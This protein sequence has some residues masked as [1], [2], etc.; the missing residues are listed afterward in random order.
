MPVFRTAAQVRQDF[1]DFFRERQHTVVPSASLVPPPGDATLLFINSGMAPFKDVFLEKMTPPAPRVADTQKCLRVS[2]KHNDLEEVGVDTY[3][4]TFFEMLGNWSFGDYFKT[5]A[6][7]WAW[8]LLTERWDLDPK[9]LYVTVHG[10]DERLGLG[11]DDEAAEIWAR[12][13]GL[14][15]SHILNGSTKDNFWMMGDTGPC[16][17]CTEIHIDLRP[18]DERAAVDGASLVNT[19]DPRVMEIWNNVFIQYNALSD[20]RLEPLPSKHVDTGMGFERITAVLQGKSSNYDTDVFSAILDAA[21][22]FSP[23]PDVKSYDALEMADSNERER[24]RIALRVVADHLRTVSFAVADGVLPGNAGRGYVIRRI[25][26]R[27]VRYAYQ[28]LGIREPLLVRLVPTLVATMGDAFPEL[29]AQQAYIERVIRAE[30]ETFLETLGTGLAA[31]SALLPHLRALAAAAEMP[32]SEDDAEARSALRADAKTMDLLVKAYGA[33]GISEVDAVLDAFSESAAAQVVPGDVA[34]LLHDTYG[35]PADLTA[36]MA[37]EEGFGLGQDAYDALMTRQKE[38]ARAAGGFKAD[39]SKIGEDWQTVSGSGAETDTQFVGYDTLRSDT[40]LAA[41]RTD[42]AQDGTVRHLVVLDETPFYAESGGQVGDTGVLHVGGEAVRVLDTVKQ[43]GRIVH[44]VDRLP[45]DLEGSVVAE[46]DASR[47]RQISQHHTATHLL[48][49]GLREVLGTHVQQKGSLVSPGRLRFD[50]SHFERVTPDELR[51]VEQYVNDFAMANV[52]LDEQRNVP[53]DEARAMGAMALFGEKYGDRVRV[54][55]FGANSVELC[56]G[57]HVSATGDVGLFRFVSEGSVAAGVRRVE[58]LAGPAALATLWADLDELAKARAPFKQTREG[59]LAA[60]IDALLQQNRALEKQLAEA[61]L[62]GLDA[63]VAAVADAAQTVRGVR[64]ATAR[65]DGADMDLL[66]ELAQRLAQRL[67][68]DGVAVLGGTDASG[69]KAL[70]AVASGDDAQKTVPA[71][72]LVGALA[73][74]VGGGGGGRPNV[75][76]AGGKNPA[77]LDAALAAAASE[78]ASL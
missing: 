66:R 41:V 44:V 21:A 78:I 6:I 18:D 16:G 72:K 19:D 8:E 11:R 14:V 38:R 39:M 34:F 67:G 4:H 37:R 48:H 57:T 40:R 60:E 62:A 65:V 31:F 61:R 74:H 47:R 12:Q 3:H 30:E 59:G 64:L 28:T 42:T 46:V 68:A 2:G 1:L 10:G 32:G 53:I 5:E 27:A 45:E 7:A 76:T 36:L 13:P 22:S 52:A 55:A 17:P 50:F 29:V 33:A 70:L 24:V 23:R 15:S 43:S 35:F 49:A 54:I 71:G 51:A 26:R 69:E 58:A 75:A 56:G 25:L 9:R 73:K 63:R 77:G 20:G